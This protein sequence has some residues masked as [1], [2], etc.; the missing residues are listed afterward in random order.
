LAASNNCI[1]G[2]I[3]YERHPLV[4]IGGVRVEAF[5][6]ARDTKLGKYRGGEWIL[7]LL[8]PGGIMIALENANRL[9]CPQENSMANPVVRLAAKAYDVR[10]ARPANE[11][12]FGG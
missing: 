12:R 4:N 9:S 11:I 10:L 5:L 6:A 7:S 1:P 3:S 8:V 2:L